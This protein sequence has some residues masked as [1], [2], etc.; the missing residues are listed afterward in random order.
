MLGLDELCMVED[1]FKLGFCFSFSPI[2][3]QIFRGYN[4]TPGQLS[5]SAWHWL[6]AFE[7]FGKK[8]AFQMTW[9]ICCRFVTLISIEET[10]VCH[11][12]STK[13]NKPA[14]FF[15]V[16]PPEDAPGWKSPYLGISPLQFRRFPTLSPLC[17]EEQ[18]GF[19]I[20]SQVKVDLS[21]EAIGEGT[22]VGDVDEELQTSLVDLMTTAQK[23]KSL[24][25]RKSEVLEP[26]ATTR[27]THS[28][29]TLESAFKDQVVAKPSGAK[30]EL[31]STSMPPLGNI[32]II[33]LASSD[34]LRPSS[35]RQKYNVPIYIPRWD[36]YTNSSMDDPVIHHKLMQGILLSEVQATRKKETMNENYDVVCHSL[37]EATNSVTLL[38]EYLAKYDKELQLSRE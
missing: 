16:N 30:Q 13:K 11:F 26:Q 8:Y 4:I 9:Q 38:Y 29:V 6:Q 5:P 17:E 3:I 14:R 18:R 21:N 34:P 22:K 27:K 19:D 15:F 25:V 2:I 36:V 23:A 37:I 32:Q 1:F 35:T 28:Q 20:L 24:I 33:D 31:S 7:M 10:G 12:S